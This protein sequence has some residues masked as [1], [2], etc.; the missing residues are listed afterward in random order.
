MIDMPIPDFLIN[1]LG[2]FAALSLGLF[3][4]IAIGAGGK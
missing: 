4:G 3:I 1:I 2:M